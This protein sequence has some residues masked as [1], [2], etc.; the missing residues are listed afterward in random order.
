MERLEQTR[1]D[2]RNLIVALVRCGMRENATEIQKSMLSLIASA[3]ANSD[4][5]FSGILTLPAE[6]QR[7]M[8]TKPELKDFEVLSLC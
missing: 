7:T 3:R 8:G 1:G 6:L 5:V 2:A 4:E